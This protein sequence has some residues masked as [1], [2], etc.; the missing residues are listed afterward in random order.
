MPAV[1]LHRLSRALSRLLKL[2]IIL[3]ILSVWNIYKSEKYLNDEDMF[4]LMNPPFLDG[5]TT[6]SC[7]KARSRPP[8]FGG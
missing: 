1:V 3:V 2:S 8:L 4:E 5:R 6:N 7:K